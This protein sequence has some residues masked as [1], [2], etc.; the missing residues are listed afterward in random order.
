MTQ[1][2]PESRAD[3]PPAWILTLA[4]ALGMACPAVSQE[5]STSGWRIL[6]TNSQVEFTGGLIFSLATTLFVDDTGQVWDTWDTSLVLTPY[7][8]DIIDSRRQPAEH[9]RFTGISYNSDST[10]FICGERGV[11]LQTKNWGRNWKPVT[12]ATRSQDAILLT[13]S[14]PAT[15]PCAT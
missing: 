14:R 3:L 13:Q 2:Y 7:K 9:V 11:L 8:L 4:L 1:I 10:G 15:A 6:E 12:S 5:D